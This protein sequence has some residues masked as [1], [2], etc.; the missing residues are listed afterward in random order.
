MN[1]PPV[2]TANDLLSMMCR[3][4]TAIC[5]V[6]AQWQ[7]AS[8]TGRAVE[9]HTLRHCIA[10]TRLLRAKFAAAWRAESA[11]RVLA[12]MTRAA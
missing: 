10:A 9:R 8:G 4:E 11:A 6:V 2:L 12:S 3:S 1:S 5:E 7:A